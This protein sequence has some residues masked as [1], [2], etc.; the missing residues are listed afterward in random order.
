MD[1]RGRVSTANCR[2]NTGNIEVEID[3]NKTTDNNPIEVLVQIKSAT[4]IE[5][6][7]FENLGCDSITVG[8]TVR[9][10]EGTLD[11]ITIRANFIENRITG[12][13]LAETCSLYLPSMVIR[14]LSLPFSVRKSPPPATAISPFR[15]RNSTTFE[16]KSADRNMPLLSGWFFTATPLSW[17]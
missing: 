17:L 1:F 11:G 15:F 5:T 2:D 9:R 7:N 14:A 6:A 10:L 4:E 8:D 16:A 13:V 3:S 12:P